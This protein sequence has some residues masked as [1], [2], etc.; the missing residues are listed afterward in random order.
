[1]NE[2]DRDARLDA[3]AVVAASYHGD[4]E[5]LAAV[6][7]ANWVCP[8]LLERLIRALAELVVMALEDG[9][10]ADVD[11]ALALARQAM[12]EQDG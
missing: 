6:L 1:V 3:I 9:P 4:E 10:P 8:V 5:A 11:K 2:A 7:G 12:L